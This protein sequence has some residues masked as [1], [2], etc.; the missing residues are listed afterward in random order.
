[1]PNTS[2]PIVYVRSCETPAPNRNAIAGPVA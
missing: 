2:Q 1:M